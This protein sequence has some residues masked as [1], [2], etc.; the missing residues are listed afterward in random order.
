MWSPETAMQT[1]EQKNALNGSVSSASQA[2]NN[3]N[4]NPQEATSKQAK[5]TDSYV[6]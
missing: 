4:N 5:E 3:T 2:G 6:F 1:I